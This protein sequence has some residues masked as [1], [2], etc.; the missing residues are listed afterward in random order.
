MIINFKKIVTIFS[1]IRTAFWRYKVR[2]VFIIVLGFIAGIL[3][4]IGV[5][6]AIPLFF[7]FSKQ[8][9]ISGVGIDA[10]TSF[11]QQTFAFFHLPF[12]LPF[13][14]FFM[15]SLLILKAVIMFFAKYINEKTMAQYVNQFKSELFERTL[16]T[17]W[18]YL[19]N[20]K[21]GYLERILF[22]DIDQGVSILDQVT[23]GILLAT[24]FIAY[25]FIALKISTTFALLTMAIG[26]VLFLFFKPIFY[27]IRKLSSQVV[28]SDKIAIHHVSENL[29]GIKAIKAAA[30]E[31]PVARKGKEFFAERMKYRVRAVIYGLPMG[32]IFEPLTFV[33]VAILFLLSYRSP[34]FNLAVFVVVVYLIQKIFSF[35]QSFQDKVGVIS[36]SAPFL[37]TILR[38]R[39]ETMKNKETNAGHD[40]FS[41]NRSLEFKDI[42]FF[43]SPD[44]Q[45]LTNVTFAIGKGQTVGIIGPSGGGKT[46]IVDLMLRLF[47]PKMGE[48]LLDGKNIFSIDINRWRKNIGYVP[49]DV[50]LLNDT[51]ENNIK[52]YEDSITE[53]QIL[54]AAEMANIIEFVNNL[55]NKFQTVVGERGVKLSGGQRQRIA[56]ARALARKP[57]LLVLDEAT[58]ALDTESETIIQN[59]IGKLKG[60]ITI[61]IVAHRLSTVMNSDTLVVIDKGKI[62]EEGVPGEMLQRPDSYLSRTAHTK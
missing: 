28:S 51:I 33:F 40:E 10:V 43:Y 12:N 7:L 30:V 38:Y 37:E 6:T 13:L 5:S 29:I 60:K 47:V 17:N 31:E 14:I 42:G 2:F 48:I 41:F 58:S 23:G 49:Q 15:I 4:S 61:V 18:E 45:I 46:T 22:N 11:I 9:N 52:F 27:R 25:G 20:H 59:A 24:N 53:K 62:I 36:Q 32:F 21:I 55:P 57:Q 19:L 44:K 16:S 56:L 50:F 26:G 1:L 54:D 34:T 35:V 39:R 3:G 8:S